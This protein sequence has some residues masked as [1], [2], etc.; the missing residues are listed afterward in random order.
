MTGCAQSLLMLPHLKWK[1]SKQHKH[2]KS[3]REEVI[4]ITLPSTTVHKTLSTLTSLVEKVPNQEA[5]AVM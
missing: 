2:I 5:D 3:G 1:D 4:L